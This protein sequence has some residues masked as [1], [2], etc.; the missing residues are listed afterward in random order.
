MKRWGAILGGVLALILT[1]CAAVNSVESEVS[2]YSQWPTE[3]KPGTYA[4]ERLPSQ[5]ANAQRQ[6]Q[7]E[8]LAKRAL[9]GAGF[10]EAHNS[11]HIQCTGT[12]PMFLVTTKH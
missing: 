1:G 2:T 4:F 11:H 9:D 8:A 3:R 12:D 7:L 6:D 5:Q 10:T